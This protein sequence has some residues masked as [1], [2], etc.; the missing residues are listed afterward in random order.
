MNI[1]ERLMRVF[2]KPQKNAVEETLE[3]LRK[4]E[5]EKAI[6]EPLK[7]EDEEE[8][9]IPVVEARI[10]GVYSLYTDYYDDESRSQYQWDRSG[11]RIMLKV[12]AVVR[13]ELYGRRRE[14]KIKDEVVEILGRGWYEEAICKAYMEL[15][16]EDKQKKME[17]GLKEMV[18]KKVC[19]EQLKDFKEEFS[20][21]NQKKE[22]DIKIEITQDN[23][24]KE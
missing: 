4:K 13:L 8:K 12:T 7:K 3:L 18:I 5:Q 20:L 11:W 16:E 15:S 10:A 2:V 19:E 23:F 9:K 21:A 24:H 1:W 6:K 14:V 22:F 17:K